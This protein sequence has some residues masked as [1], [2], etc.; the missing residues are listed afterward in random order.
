MKV[1]LTGANGFVGSH[2]L[3]RLIEA[4]HEVAVMLRRTSNTRF[5]RAHLQ[6]VEV[7]YGSL[8]SPESLRQ[9]LAGAEAVVHC[10]GR[11]KAVRRADYYAANAQGALHVA[12]A[13]NACADTV[14]QLVLISSLAATGPGTPGSPARGDGPARPV[15]AYGRSKLLGERHV[16]ERCRVPFTILRPAAV[17]GP[18]DGDF[19]LI[20]RAVRGGLA[21]MVSASQPLS[22]IYVGDV[23]QAVV[24]SIGCARGFGNVYH[25]AHPA[26]CTQGELVRAV[27]Q[28]LDARP[29]RLPLPAPV[30]YPV[31]L[32][33]GL[34][35]RITG[36]PGI[37]NMDKIAEYRAAGWVCETAAAR[38]DLGFVADT[39]LE[40]G[41]RRTAEWYAEA[42]WL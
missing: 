9:A 33:R 5:L 1:L 24:R 22:L 18:R 39:A 3:E 27:A 41:L 40:E 17:Y 36:R 2:V 32:A 16:R 19:L 25:L 29:V 38:E 13:C 35:A 4:D 20:F 26:P 37:L 6:R 10:A 15:S 23:A 30:L 34:W 8:E 11:T 28:A 42:G 14:R 31:C 21:P 7:R 12:E